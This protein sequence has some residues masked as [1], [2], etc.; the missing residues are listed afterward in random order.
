[1]ELKVELK[2]FKE[3]KELIEKTIRKIPE[4]LSQEG[5][6]EIAM[7]YVTALQRQV[8]IN[9]SVASGRLRNNF[10]AQ[11]V[12]DNTVHVSVLGRA[13]RYAGLLEQTYAFNRGPPWKAIESWAKAKGIDTE[14]KDSP[15]RRIYWSLK[16][17][18]PKEGHP[19]VD[20]AM[21]AARRDVSEII[22]RHVER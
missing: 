1:M 4:N 14:G 22:K 6:D 20:K 11:R 2:G 3:A 15:A 10:R 8:E 21:V 5:L 19:Y 9:D 18:T 16:S 7:A 13:A 12:E 17:G